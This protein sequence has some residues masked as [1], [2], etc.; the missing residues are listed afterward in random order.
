MDAHGVRFAHAQ[1]AVERH[2][3]AGASSIFVAVDG[4]LEAVVG[5]RRRAAPGEPRGRAGAQGRRAARGDPDVG[6]RARGRSKPS[7]R[8]SGSTGDRRAVAG[9]QGAARERAPA[10][11]Q[12]RRDGRRRHQRRARARGRRRR[13]L[14][15]RRHRRRARDGRRRAARGGPR[16]APRRLRGR[17]PARCDTCGAGSGSSSC[18]TPSRSCSA[19]SACHARRGGAGEQRVDR[20][21]GAGGGV[22]ALATLEGG[23]RTCSRATCT[24]ASP[25]R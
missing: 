8:A 9:G 16:E 23:D 13:H 24:E 2:R 10:R 7:A 14:A 21:G 22:A 1:A 18:R 17:R 25:E 15:R 3:G 11:G 5:V 12:D 6:R 19:R 20:R 4:V